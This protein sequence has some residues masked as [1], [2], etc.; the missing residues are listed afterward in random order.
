MR[1][2]FKL[3]TLPR[4]FSFRSLA[5]VVSEG[6]NL[7]PAWRARLAKAG[8][9]AYAGARN[10]WLRSRK[11]CAI[12]SASTCSCLGRTVSPAEGST[13]AHS[14]TFA[15]LEFGCD[16]SR[17]KSRGWSSGLKP[18]FLINGGNREADRLQY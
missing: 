12:R 2:Q 17:E 8:A 11:T 6:S 15:T 4:E 14:Q 3:S 10:R 5:L 7:C 16:V 1:R 9:F 18:G 13:S